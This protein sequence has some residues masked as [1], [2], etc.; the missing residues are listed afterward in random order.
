MEFASRCWKAAWDSDSNACLRRR[1]S[2]KQSPSRRPRQRPRPS[3]RREQCDVGG[4]LEDER[5]LLLLYLYMS[6]L[7]AIYICIL[8]RVCLC[9]CIFVCAYH[10][11]VQ[12]LAPN[13]RP[14]TE[15]L[16]QPMLR[17]FLCPAGSHATSRLL[18]T[19]TKT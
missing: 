8:M 4:Y 1:R 12:I 14:I 13:P 3:R 16:F 19:K 2:R 15:R 6:L 7:S 18:S 10:I 5:R 11:N 9:I 17:G